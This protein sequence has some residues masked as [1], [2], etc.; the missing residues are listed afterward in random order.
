MRTCYTAKEALKLLK[1]GNE[2]FRK[3]YF[4]YHVNLASRCS[5]GQTPFAI[6]LTCSDSRTPPEILFDQGLGDLF[7]VRTAG[8][9]I[10]QTVLGSIEFAVYELQVPLLVV[11][12]HDDCGAVKAAVRVV[13]RGEKALN[14]PESGVYKIID[15]I[16]PVVEKVKATGVKGEE[17]VNL[18]IEWNVKHAIEEIQK[19]PMIQTLEQY[20]ILQ[21]RG[22]KYAIKTGE[23]KFF[24]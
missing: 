18:A 20:G 8:N 7:V 3:G 12:G 21:V 5:E 16:V 15:K 19:S 6:V 14:V 23:V 11:M 10:D 13:V 17:L 2:R 9:V 1:E 4:S 24:E 22:A